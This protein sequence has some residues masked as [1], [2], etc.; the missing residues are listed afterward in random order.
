[1]TQRLWPVAA[2]SGTAFDGACTS[3][4]V[5]VTS[6]SN[7]WTLNCTQATSTGDTATGAT[8][9][10]T[11][12]TN[13]NPYGNSRVN[14]YQGAAIVDAQDYSAP[15]VVNGVTNYPVDGL[16]FEV[17]PN[18]MTLAAG[19]ALVEHHSTPQF[20]NAV[21]SVG[22]SAPVCYS[23]NGKTLQFNGI[24]ANGGGTDDN[25]GY[26]VFNQTPNSAYQYFGGTM[27][28]VPYLVLKG[29]WA[30]LIYLDQ[31]PPPENYMLYSP[32]C[33]PSPSSCTDGSYWYGLYQFQGNGGSNNAQYFPETNTMEWNGLHQFNSGLAAGNNGQFNVSSNGAVAEPSNSLNSGHTF[34]R[35][36]IVS[37]SI[38]PSSVAANTC[39]AQTATVTGLKAGD[40]VINRDVLPSF[41][42]G[43]SLDG[44]IVT[45]ANTVSMNWCNV[46]AAAIAPPTGTYTFDVEQ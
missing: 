38:T 34:T 10:L 43:L 45:G 6:N 17:E 20:H 14:F 5:S 13:D 18:E 30:N 19:D 41:T 40:H 1:M 35:H 26:F 27:A 28:P 9:T 8:I 44:I 21:D 33:P 31:P 37:G 24:F 42:A 12:P 4:T 23:C 32:N 29:M 3:A 22:V 7:I 36:D 46:T 39:A 16:Q 15:I 25:N 11:D 2:I